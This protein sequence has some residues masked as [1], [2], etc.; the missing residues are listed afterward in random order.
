M[1]NKKR[2]NLIRL[3]SYAKP[4]F[5]WFAFGLALI[6]IA[7]ISSLIQPV[8]VQRMIDTDIARLASGAANPELQGVALSGILRTTLLYL[9]MTLITFIAGYG[10]T[11]LLNY[12]GQK[13]LKRI[14]QDLYDHILKL[15]MS[16][17]DENAIGSIVTRV[18]ND[19]ETLN[20]MFTTVLSNV[21]NNLFQLTGIIL[22][23]YSLNPGLASLVIILMPV[24]LLIS[25][26]F[27][28]AIRRVYEQQRRIL[29]MINAKLAENISGITVIQLFHK[30]KSIYEEFD[31]ENKGYL[32]V[33]EVEVKY[34]S[35]YRPAIEIVRTLGIA[36]LIWFGGQGS[37]NGA[38]S[39][40]VLYAFIDYIQR[41]Y[42]PILNLAE[43]FNV[44]QSAMT[45]SKRI[46]RLMDREEEDE[47]GDIL[48]GEDFR[49]AIEFS[50][51]WFSYDKESAD[52]EKEWILRDVSFSIQAGHFVA[53]VGATGAGKTTIMSLI[54]RFYDVDKGAVLIDG[55]NVKDYNLEALRKKIGVVQQDVFLFTGNIMDNI[56]L[57]RPEVSEEM[58]ME[59]ARK[60]NV[61][62]FIE[63]LPKAY[64]QPVT[65][66]G[67][68]FSAGQRQLLSFA[69][70]ISA[71]P[72]ILILDEAT[73]NIDTE[74]EE[75]I[76]DAII[77]MTEDRTTLAV[78]HRISTIADADL[79]IV[80]HHG[81]VAEQGT[82]DELIE[83]DGLFRILYDLQY[84]NSVS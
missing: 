72:N 49:G 58:A 10:S 50:H 67:S 62:R 24:I 63:S 46:F 7:T 15:P 8:L 31:E 59:A 75:L 33:G 5:P 38:I 83:K 21:F 47:G 81:R 29:S 74:T 73:S 41:F 40:G 12:L 78:A 18:T 61:D 44:I 53:F 55:I 77:T 34:F 27:R 84:K 51:V 37:L 68:T 11:Y 48:P 20:E 23:M 65:E 70:T 30:Q 2:S 4:H 60:V 3:Y 42:Q 6:L 57:H 56:S 52:E 80:M 35:I 26:I 66:R 71:N 82:R 19:T 76:Q 69:R 1:K 32:K 14:R 54:T 28:R 13:I 79:I 64:Q 25:V 36:L 22:I 43:T 16:F 17:Y 9:L 45:S 39:F